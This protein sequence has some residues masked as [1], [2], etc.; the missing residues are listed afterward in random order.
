MSFHYARRLYNFP[1]NGLLQFKFLNDVDRELQTSG[2]RF[3]VL[4]WPDS[5]VD[6][7]VATHRAGSYPVAFSNNDLAFGGHRHIYLDL[8]PICYPCLYELLLHR[9]CITPGLHLVSHCPCIFGYRLS[10]SYKRLARTRS[11][12]DP[13]PWEGTITYRNH[14]PG[15]AKANLTGHLSGFLG[16][17]AGWWMGGKG[18]PIRPLGL[19]FTLHAHEPVLHLKAHSHLDFHR[20]PCHFPRLENITNSFVGTP[21]EWVP[22]TV[23][24]APQGHFKMSVQWSVSALCDVHSKVLCFILSNLGYWVFAYGFNGFRFDGVTTMLQHHHS[25]AGLGGH[26]DD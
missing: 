17:G 19:R 16:V 13:L 26:Y 5:F 14:V 10:R 23:V 15:A 9:K 12:H 2:K 22:V 20:Q 4:N 8:T 21:F 25:K 11:G 24:R 7:R 18:G 6:Y 3:S 1:D